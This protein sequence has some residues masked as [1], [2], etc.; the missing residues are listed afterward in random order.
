MPRLENQKGIALI[1]VVFIIALG[2]IIVVNLTYTTYIRSRINSYN[3]KAVQAEYLLKSSV[4]FARALILEDTTP[5]DSMQ[6]DWASFANGTPVP[7]E[8]LGIN[9]PSL[10]NL[11]IYLEIGSEE[12]KVPL[13]QLVQGGAS[14]NTKWRDVLHRLFTRLGFDEDQ[15]EDQTKLFAGRVFSSEE[16]VANLI[17]Y[18]DLD[19]DSYDDGGNFARGIE[20]EL[21]EDYFPNKQISRVA[22]LSTIPG[23]TPTRLRKLSPLLTSLST[24]YININLAPAIVLYAL[25]DDMGDQEV[26]SVI[27][28]RQSTPFDSN[29][30]ANELPTL[31][32]SDVATRLNTMLRYQSNYFQVIAKVD[33]GTSTYFAR[34]ILSQQRDGTVP[35]IR[36]FELF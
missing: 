33:Y 21:P 29:S 3:S 31:I 17:D 27:S 15:E 12:A 24:G 13:N 32:G 10:A 28:F 25:D 22:E 2:S 23:F 26:E 6:D 35:K 19:K 11:A 7:L 20:A 8:L 16:L 18:I 4:N 36:S 1:L 34:T 14:V 30:I 5:E 9:N